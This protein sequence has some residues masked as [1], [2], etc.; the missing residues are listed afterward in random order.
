MFTNPHPFESR[1]DCGQLAKGLAKA[2]LIPMSPLAREAFL[3]F[4]EALDRE[5][6]LID[7][8]RAH[9]WPGKRVWCRVDDRTWIST[10]IDNWNNR[11]E[12]LEAFL[13]AI[14]DSPIRQWACANWEA[15]QRWVLEVVTDD[16]RLVTWRMHAEI[17][18]AQSRQSS[19]DA[20]AEVAPGGVET[21]KA[22]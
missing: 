7:H 11:N 13:L 3:R 12:R 9:V 10:L 20:A 6:D 19:E 16:V 5:V 2:A 1:V 4:P 18:A 8:V 14:S 17:P 15:K 22:M 21:K